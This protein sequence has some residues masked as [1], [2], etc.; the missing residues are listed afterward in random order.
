MRNVCT[1]LEQWS[2]GGPMER[3]Q[4][5]DKE[6]NQDGTRDEDTPCFII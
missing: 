6:D 2:R 5:E 1:E 3:G 4:Q